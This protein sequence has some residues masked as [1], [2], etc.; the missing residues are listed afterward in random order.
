MSYYITSFCYGQKY[1]P[2][3]DIWCNRICNNVKILK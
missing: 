3:K 1:D 2:I